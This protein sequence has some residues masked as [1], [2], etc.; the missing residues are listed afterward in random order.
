MLFSSIFILVL[1][2]ARPLPAA[3]TRQAAVQAI[4]DPGSGASVDTAQSVVWSPYVDFGFGPG[5]QGLVPAGSSIDPAEMGGDPYPG[6]GIALSTDSYFFWVDDSPLTDFEHPVRFVIVDAANPSPTVSNG[7]VHVSNQGWWPVIAL[8]SQSPTP[9]FAIDSTRV[10]DMPPAWDNPNGLVGG[11]APTFADLDPPQPVAFAPAFR[12]S[13][14]PAPPAPTAAALI[15]RGD[16]GDRFGN[17]VK[18]INQ[19]LKNV[20]G[21]PPGRIVTAGNGDPATGGTAA[22]KTDLQNA[23]VKLCALNPPPSVIYVRITSHGAKGKLKLKGGS[24]DKVELCNILK[25]LNGK[26]VSIHYVISSCYSGSL[27]DPTIWG[28]PAGSSLITSADGLEPSPAGPVVPPSMDRTI[29]EGLF[30]HAFSICSN[31]PLADVNHDQRVDDEEAFDW[32]LLQKPCYS[33]KEK[34]SEMAY[35]AGPPNGPGTNPNPQ[36]IVLALA[37]IGGGPTPAVP[38]LLIT[39]NPFR[40]SVRIDYPVMAPGKIRLEVLDLAG[41]AVRILD[42]GFAVSQGVRTAIWDG[43]DARGIR[44]PS[45]LYLCRLGSEGAVVRGK[46]L[47]M[48]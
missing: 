21:V 30:L 11:A 24:I 32:V 39:P 36:K 12:T 4:L 9:F 28:A 23:I 18:R 17:N 29:N 8:P 31:E 15:V 45:G 22:T 14:A 46:I 37:A 48:K 33:R 40:T 27:T 42:D 2:A 5:F 3:I 1:T 6:P 26:N 25:Q 20:K 7:G 35:P 16:D 10:S 34:R 38:G 44:V 13:V 19:D 43:R 47:F 41:R